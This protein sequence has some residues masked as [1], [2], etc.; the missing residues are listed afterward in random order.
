[1]ECFS[2]RFVNIIQKYLL[3]IKVIIDN[4]SDFS[5]MH[6][7]FEMNLS[8]VLFKH[9]HIYIYKIKGTGHYW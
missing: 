3:I 8:D 5:K 2:I 9:L 6:P 4:N 7:P 1:M